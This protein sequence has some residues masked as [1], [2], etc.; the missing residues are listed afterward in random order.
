MRLSYIS[1]RRWLQENATLCSEEDLHN[2]GHIIDEAIP[3]V[4]RKNQEI[5]EK[6]TQIVQLA[7][8]AWT[9]KLSRAWSAAKS[10]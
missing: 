5:E 2:L 4:E 7:R 3:V 9:R 10:N 6:L 8:E 1:V